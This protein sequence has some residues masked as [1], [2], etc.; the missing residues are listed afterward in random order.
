MHLLCL[1]VQQG[2]HHQAGR[3]HWYVLLKEDMLEDLTVVHIV[4]GKED[5]K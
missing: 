3:N 5:K 2:R 4:E 1:G